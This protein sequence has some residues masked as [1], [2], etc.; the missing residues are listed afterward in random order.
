MIKLNGKL[1]S[2]SS[3]A[4]VLFSSALAGQAASVTFGPTSWVN[5]QNAAQ[6]TEWN[7]TIDDS[8][9]AAGFDYR[10]S[11]DYVGGTNIGSLLGF[12]A[13][14]ILDLT[15]ATFSLV[16]SNVTTSLGTPCIGSD[17]TSCGG[18]NWNGGGGSSPGGFE[19]ILPT[20]TPG[21]STGLLTNLVFDLGVTNSQLLTEDL[22]TSVGLRLQE[23]GPAPDGA[24]GSLKAWNLTGTYDDGC[25]DG[26]V[27][28]PITGCSSVTTPVPLPAGLPLLLSALGTCA[29][30]RMR[31]RKS[32]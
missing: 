25:P 3:A 27:F 26:Q 16:S 2:I 11:I 22:F 19:F 29:L 15:G 5:E 12:G 10:F 13:G 18:L 1:K 8:T 28:D 20:N 32:A 21:T 14:T 4:I 24:G 17:I 23:Y 31:T 30:L 6:Q 9:A 7:V